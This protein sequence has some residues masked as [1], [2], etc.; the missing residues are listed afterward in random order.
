MQPARLL[1]Q[2]EARDGR[3]AL[4]HDEVGTPC[5]RVEVGLR[6]A[7]DRERPREAELL[8]RLVDDVREPLV[9]DR[10][11][12]RVAVPRRQRRRRV[13]RLR[14]LPRR[15]LRR[16]GGRRRRAGRRRCGR[17]R[18]RRRRGR[19]RLL[20][21]ECERPA[22]RLLRGRRSVLEPPI[23]EPPVVGAAGTHQHRAHRAGVLARLDPWAEGGPVAGR[24]HGS[25]RRARRVDRRRVGH[26]DERLRVAAVEIDEELE[27]LRRHDVADPARGDGD[28]LADRLHAVARLGNAGREDGGGKGRREGGDAATA[29]MTCNRNRRERRQQPE[30]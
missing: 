13:P 14:A 27:P 23:V 3:I 9:L 17:G 26:P 24:H 25:G 4:V 1:A 19:R 2:P 28:R 29:H 20:E 30:G 10:A 15:R 16:R 6:P 7:A 18:S 22:D 5:D 8:H 11:L 12:A 21:P